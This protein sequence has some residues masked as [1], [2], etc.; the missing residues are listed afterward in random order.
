MTP[1]VSV[2]VPIYN[3]APYLKR[4]LASLIA[5]DYTALEL[6]LV[7]DRSTDDS[8]AI[9]AQLAATDKRVVPVYLGQNRGVSAARNAGLAVATGVYVAFMDGDDWLAPHTIAAFVAALEAGPYDLVTCPF[10]I[11]APQPKPLPQRLLVDREL[12]RRQLLR[13]ML[14]PVGQ[15][16]GYLWN[17]IYR[18]SVIEAGHLRFD[19]TVT[20]MEDEL[21][22]TE[23]ALMTSRFFFRGRP[24]Y[25]HVVRADS[26]TQ[27]LGVLGALPQQLSALWRI[28]QLI[29]AKRPVSTEMP[30][31]VNR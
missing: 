18:R 24:G 15:I 1:L 21:F 16:R 8:A 9:I 17:K 4:S 27:S 29:R 11:D 23:Y 22:T 31:K 30:I 10:Y 13:G 19:E 20:I 14:A 26:A 5:Q 25:H 12:S 3:L 7:D 6:I 28:Q 2:I